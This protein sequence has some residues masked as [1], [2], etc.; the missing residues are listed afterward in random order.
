MRIGEIPEDRD[1]MTL[2]SPK[3]MALTLGTTKGSL[4]NLVNEGRIPHLHVGRNLRFDR[5]VVIDWIERG[6]A[7]VLGRFACPVCAENQKRRRLK[8]EKRG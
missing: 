8:T 1:R 3:D 5:E 2:T 7:L 6:G 4:Y